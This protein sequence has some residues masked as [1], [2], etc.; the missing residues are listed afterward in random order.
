MVAE[1]D[2]AACRGEPPFSAV[3]SSQHHQNKGWFSPH[4]LPQ[5]D[6]PAQP[7]IFISPKWLEGL[8]G[9]GQERGEPRVSF[10]LT[11][12]APPTCGLDTRKLYPTTRLVTSY[13]LHTEVRSHQTGLAFSSFMTMVL[14]IGKVLCFRRC[15]SF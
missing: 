6:P 9:E 15:L 13:N 10:T 12:P 2:T 7:F 11:D 5:P 3:P 1:T 4:P 14:H 8:A